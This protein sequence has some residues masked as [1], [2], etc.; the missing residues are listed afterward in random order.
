MIN[1]SSDHLAPKSLHS[2]QESE[3]VADRTLS[4]LVIRES[5]SKRTRNVYKSVCSDATNSL[6]K[7]EKATKSIEVSIP[8]KKTNLSLMLEEA[9]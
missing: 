1:D 6:E 2:V 7:L 3:S 5:V 9:R 4:P 8:I